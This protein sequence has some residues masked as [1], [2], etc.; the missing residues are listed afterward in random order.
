MGVYDARDGT[1][2]PPEFR[3]LGRIEPSSGRS[4]KLGPRFS[5]KVAMHFSRSCI[6]R[7]VFRDASRSRDSIIEGGKGDK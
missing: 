4:G 3:R 6:K 1:V 2:I 7:G 5:A